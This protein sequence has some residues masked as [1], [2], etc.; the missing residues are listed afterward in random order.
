MI[1]SCLSRAIASA[2]QAWLKRRRWLAVVLDTLRRCW[3]ADSWPT[4]RFGNPPT[5][6][7][8]MTIAGSE[9]SP[10]GLPRGHDEKGTAARTPTHHQAQDRAVITSFALARSEQRHSQLVLRTRPALEALL[11]LAPSCCFQREEHERCELVAR[12]VGQQAE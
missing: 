9:P 5:V 6:V 1:Q 12:R 8:L 4:C 11:A 3:R 10:P 2:I 7:S